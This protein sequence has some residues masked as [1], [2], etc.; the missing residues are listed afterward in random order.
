MPPRDADQ[1]AQAERDA[2]VAAVLAVF[3]QAEADRPVDPERVIVRRL[4]RTEYNNTIR[5]LC[6][7]EFEPSE[8]FPSDDP[9]HGFDNQG[10]SLSLLERYLDAAAAIVP[11]ALAPA[12][13]KN[14]A[15]RTGFAQFIVDGSR[16]PYRVSL[17]TSEPLTSTFRLAADGD[18]LV[19][20]EG[21]PIG[22]RSAEAALLVDGR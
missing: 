16:M 1:P 3:R 20:I 8:N 6:M 14:P 17:F 21:K 12:V 9:S 5:D 2:F 13:P 7:I 15:V 19:R 10:E 18:Y 22:K 11:R 4:N